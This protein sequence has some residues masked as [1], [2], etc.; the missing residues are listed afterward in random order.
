MLTIKVIIG[1]LRKESLNKKL[2]LA[3]DKLNHPNLEFKILDIHQIPLYNQDIE[4]NP[5][6]S[7]TNLKNEIANAD[8]II[9]AT[10]EYNR[11]IPGVL[12]NIIDWG[13][14]PYGKNSWAN[15]AVAIIGTSPGNVGTA[16]AQSHLRSILVGIDMIVMGQPEV[17]IT[18]KE[19]LIDE[20]YNIT[21]EGTKN[22][23]QKFLDTFSNWVEFH[24]SKS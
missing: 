8:G 11:S 7:V 12:K 2:I 17:Y 10:P 23:L 21:N 13:S 20:H 5:P 15:K 19:D 6:E 3:L 1:S 14:R 4:L 16:V 22:Y 24:H 9:I 18:F